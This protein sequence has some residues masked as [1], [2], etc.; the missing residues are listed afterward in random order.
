MTISD[1]EISNNSL[2]GGD[3]YGG[4]LYWHGY[5]DSA[6]VTRTRITCNTAT[7]SNSGRG[8]GVYAYPYENSSFSIT[9]CTVADNRL[10]GGSESYGGGLYLY[11]RPHYSYRWA[12]A[13]VTGSTISG[14]SAYGASVGQ[15]GGI[16]AFLSNEGSRSMHVVNSTVSG[17]RAYGSATASG[18]GVYTSVSGSTTLTQTTVTLNE[19]AYGGGIYCASGDVRLYNTIVAGNE[20]DIDAPDAYGEFQADS[21]SN[22]V[23][24]I[25]GSTGLDAESTQFGTAAVPLDPRL[26]TLYD[27]GGPTLTH[28]LLV[29]SPASNAGD[30]TLAR[31]QGGS[32]LLTDQRGGLHLR[33]LDGTVDVGAYEGWA[34]TY[35][36]LTAP[37]EANIFAAWDTPISWTGNVPTSSEI[38]AAKT[39]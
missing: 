30:N 36:A 16:Y 25:N 37:A 20:A 3:V 10:S 4:G 2:S 21:A 18:G 27:N 12:N 24:I 33:I 19:A 29:D 38:R 23:G 34:D 32:G 39:R 6:S 15:G 17:N 8:G 35:F 22:V 11:I 28:A 9:D 13:V 7:G 14:N 5:Y 26:S 1:S 31:D